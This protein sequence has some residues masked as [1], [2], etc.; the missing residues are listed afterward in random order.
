M[1][2]QLPLRKVIF[3]NADAPHAER[4]LARLGVSRHFE[5]IIDIQ[6]L[7]YINKP[8]AA[9]YHRA[10]DILSARPEECVFVDDS[11]NN[12]VP[13]RHMGMITVLVGDGKNTAGADYQIRSITELETLPAL[14]P[15]PR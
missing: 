13:A 2:A 8:D 11:M 1:L 6:A 9:A 7:E 15:N 10:M 14:G 3:T 5:R 4:V 12:L